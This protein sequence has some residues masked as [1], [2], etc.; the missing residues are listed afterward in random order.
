MKPDASADKNP[1]AAFAGKKK[2]RDQALSDF[3]QRKR[4]V[5]GS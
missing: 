4:E 3:K 2:P 5:R 1:L